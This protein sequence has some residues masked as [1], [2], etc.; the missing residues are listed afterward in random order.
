MRNIVKFTK[1]SLILALFLGFNLVAM[2]QAPPPPDTNGS[3]TNMPAGVG[4]GAPI[5]SGIALLLSLGAAY[6]GKKVYKAFQ[7]NE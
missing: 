6:G 7:V 5:G 4:G 3:D 2:A 1:V